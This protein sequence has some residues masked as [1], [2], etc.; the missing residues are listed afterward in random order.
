LVRKVRVINIQIRNSLHALY[1][2]NM[3]TRTKLWQD[4]IKDFIN[5]TNAAKQYYQLQ[6]KMIK[7][8]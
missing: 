8:M 2:Y 1:A 3:N 7:S 5:A 6:N 4:A